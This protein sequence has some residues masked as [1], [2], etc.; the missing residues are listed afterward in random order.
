MGAELFGADGQTGT[1]KLTVAFRNFVKA[2]KS[3]EVARRCQYVL[4]YRKGLGTRMIRLDPVF[5][6]VFVEV[7]ALCVGFQRDPRTTSCNVF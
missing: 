5:Q 7:L 6:T 1:T 3:R 4:Q 2:S